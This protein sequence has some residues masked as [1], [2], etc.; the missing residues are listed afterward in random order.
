M[1]DPT[2]NAR[3]IGYEKSATEARKE[4]TIEREVA[5]PFLHACQLQGFGTKNQGRLT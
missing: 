4:M 3:V 5:N 2:T 1:E